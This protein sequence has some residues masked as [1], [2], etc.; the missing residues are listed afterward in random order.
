MPAAQVPGHERAWQTHREAA[1]VLTEAGGIIVL[2]PVPDPLKA[3]A[4]VFLISSENV[5]R[6]HAAH[7]R[8]KRSVAIREATC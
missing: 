5:L 6:F 2:Q 3:I 4:Q 1:A 7:S 8:R